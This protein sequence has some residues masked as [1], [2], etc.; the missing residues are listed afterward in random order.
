MPLNGS[1]PDSAINLHVFFHAPAGSDDE[2]RLQDWLDWG[3]PLG[4]IGATVTPKGSPF[5]DQSS[6][7]RI[8]I[9]EQ[10]PL[11]SMPVY[12]VCSDPDS[13]REL[14]RLLL[15]ETERSRGIDTGWIRIVLETPHRSLRLELRAS[16]NVA[17]E[18]E[19]PTVTGTVGDVVGMDP[20]AVLGELDALRAVTDAALTSIEL[21]T[22]ATFMRGQFNAPP[23]YED[24]Y[25]PIA[26]ALIALQPH[27]T[28]LL[29]MP[30]LPD[31]T[32]C[33]F[34]QGLLHAKVFNGEPQPGTW[35][36]ITLEI[37]DDAAEAEQWIQDLRAATND[38]GRVYTATRPNLTLG[39]ETI[40]LNGEVVT[41]V[42][43][44]AIDTAALDGAAPGDLVTMTPAGDDRA[45]TFLH[46][47][48][49][50]LQQIDEMAAAAHSDPAAR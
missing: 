1:D 4:E 7:G 35:G 37:P 48:G 39:T 26:E 22:G 45:T 16:T 2:R 33:Q 25:R 23:A 13:G 29:R 42:H 31:V 24:L 34:R 50:T 40:Q 10:Q 18:R 47:Y 11:K 9:G 19:D 36:Q 6:G 46:T 17:G 3:I 32:K 41:I 44:P 15:E 27:T 12:I 14:S 28:Q 8:R 43:A 38:V 30:H 49:V 5:G 20:R 21:Y